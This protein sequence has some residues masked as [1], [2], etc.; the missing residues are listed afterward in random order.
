MALKCARHSTPTQWLVNKNCLRFFKASSCTFWPA[1]GWFFFFYHVLFLE[2]WPEVVSF[3]FCKRWQPETMNLR[4]ESVTPTN[5][6]YNMHLIHPRNLFA[7]IFAQVPHVTTRSP[8]EHHKAKALHVEAS[9]ACCAMALTQ[10]PSPIPF[11]IQRVR[12]KNSIVGIPFCS[13]CVWQLQESEWPC[14]D[15]ECAQWMRTWY[16]DMQEFSW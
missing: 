10:S 15:I 4:V 13:L 12:Q 5:G 6:K 7:W 3:Q 14:K 9:W 11:K 8:P 1:K 2:S 16:A